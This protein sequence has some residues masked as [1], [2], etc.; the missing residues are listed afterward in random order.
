VNWTQAPD[1]GRIPFRVRIGVTGHRDLERD[2]KLQEVPRL[3]R[4]LL[5]ESDA[6]P[7]RL[8]AVSALAEG[9]DRLIV[10]EVFAH[11]DRRGQK[12]RLEVVLPFEKMRYIELQ[13]FSAAATAEFEAWLERS[14]SIIELN[15]SWEPNGR[16][17]SYAAAG[18]HVV[19]R[20]DILVALWDGKP[21]RG[22]GGTAETLLYA[23]EL[24]KPC[25]WIATE[26]A[27]PCQDN[28]TEEREVAFLEE[29]RRRAGIATEGSSNRATT[30]AQ[31]LTPLR[32]A[33]R[34]LDDFNT[35]PVPPGIR[36]APRVESELS[37][38]DK[39]SDW[40]TGPF[41]RA[42]CLADRYQSWFTSA[43]WLMSV[44]ATGAAAC[45]AASLIQES[46]SRIWAWAEV[47]CLLVLVAAFLLAHRL[48]LH[49]RWLAYR[50]LAERLRSAYFVAPTG[51][52]FRRNAGLEAVFVERRSAEWPLRAFEE[53]WDSRPGAV[54]R[55]RSLSR[56]DVESLKSRLADQWIGG[57]IAFHEGARRHHE[58]RGAV[59]TW[60]ILLFFAGTI[61]F[62]A[63]HAGTHILERASIFFTV[64]LPVAAAA[65]G[66]ILTVR[67]HRALAERYARMQSDLVSVRRSLLDV[68]RQTIG[69]ATSEAARVV[70][71]ENGDWFG[72][73]WFLDVEHPP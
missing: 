51:I 10:E 16:D 39:S 13:A 11:E 2:R 41:G 46:P 19:N 52:D 40:V 49:R 59:L 56:E 7:L 37:G 45:L 60:L 33:F 70:A 55:S 57:Q 48:G 21:S 64:T 23:A 22:R 43:T 42:A 53:V 38:L 73:M 63:L 17:A 44:L 26:G 3:V 5:P 54:G 50:L 71:E 29:V 6:T 20:C 61:L 1:V 72:A 31:V 28:F 15:G 24:G 25:I 18:Q 14:T 66:V 8:A 62:A 27:A 12:A 34:E 68:D 32:E 65:L 30:A 47:A 67:Q 58:R 69:K 36:L 9:A 35:S 4:N